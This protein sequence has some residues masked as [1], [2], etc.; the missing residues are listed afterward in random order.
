LMRRDAYAAILFLLFNII[1]FMT[2]AFC[3]W[4]FSSRKRPPT[5]YFQLDHIGIVLHIW[6]TS[7]SVLCLEANNSE[8]HWHIILGITLAGA[9]SATCLVVPRIGKLE[10]TLVIAGFGS[11]SLSSVLFYNLTYSRVSRMT[12]S[13]VSMVMINSIGGWFYCRGS[14]IHIQGRSLNPFVISGHSLMH[15]CSV[16]A[17]TIHSSVLVYSVCF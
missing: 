14:K 16:L 15:V 10:R 5:F 9:V 4:M 8:V 6:A 7:L 13:Y 1:C 11:I 3:H 2:S 12:I 17:S